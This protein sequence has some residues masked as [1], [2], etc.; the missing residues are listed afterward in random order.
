M[1]IPQF[2]KYS[3]KEGKFKLEVFCTDCNNK[4]IQEFTIGSCKT[5][6]ELFNKKV[7]EKMEQWKDSPSPEYIKMFRA[8]QEV[9][10]EEKQEKK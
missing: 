5:C 8:M 6:S 2:K 4:F 9:L 10:E 7:E 3:S 1:E